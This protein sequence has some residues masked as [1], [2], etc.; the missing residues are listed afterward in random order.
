MT[1]AI[2]LML[3]LG[4]GA[5]VSGA[6]LAGSPERELPT[7]ELF[8]AAT[9]PDADLDEEVQ[10]PS[11]GLLARRSLELSMLDAGWLEPPLPDVVPASH[12]D[13][14]GSL[15]TYDQIPRRW[16][17]PIDYD[18]YRYPIDTILGLPPVV[19]GYDLDQPDAKQRRSDHLHAVGH[20]G[21]DLPQ[22]MGAPIR[23]VPLAHQVGDAKVVFVGPLFGNTVVTLHAVREG[24]AKHHYVLIFGHLSEAAPELAP[25][26]TLREGDLVGLVG[27]SE[28][29]NLV[30][31]HLEA[32][33]LR[34]DVDPDRLGLD[35]VIA[36]TVVTDPR[37][38]LPTRPHRAAL[39]ATCASRM[40]ENQH[41]L[42]DFRLERPTTTWP[43]PLPL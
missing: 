8:T 29:P 35:G 12:T 33:R 37:N 6:A 30:H 18:A 42:G 2:A 24:G 7:L 31:L 22:V 38:V 26:K 28:S 39:P 32:R 27:D 40:L 10:P 34:D 3:L 16:D 1:G 19:S 9:A 21:V 36:R 11:C 14:D 25:R 15:V 13:K 4:S 17:R 41:R 20:G 5:G 43:T 23:M